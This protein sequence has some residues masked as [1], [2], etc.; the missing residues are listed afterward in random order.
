[1]NRRL[2]TIFSMSIVL[3]LSVLAESRE[4]YRQAGPAAAQ[5]DS[6]TALAITHGPYLQLPT[7]TSMTVVWHTNKKCVSKV[8][9]GTDERFGLTAI[10]SRNG[11]IDNDR[12]SHAIRLSGLKP[13]VTYKYRV[14]SREFGGYQKQHIVTFGET[15]A[16]PVYQF[17]TLDPAKEGFSFSM[18][19]DIHERAADLES[20]VEPE[21]F[22]GRRFCRIQRRHA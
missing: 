21:I 16:S 22:R 20:Y 12:T 13:G 4:A 3:A 17:T 5:G 8:E 18:V 7:G 15:V 14:V 2:T 6:G 1:M 11:L 9:Y 19:S 10:S